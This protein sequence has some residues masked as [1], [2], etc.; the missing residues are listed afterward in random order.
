MCTT[1]FLF[2]KPQLLSKNDFTCIY[3]YIYLKRVP[4][5]PSIPL[6]KPLT[7]FSIMGSVTF[8]FVTY[9]WE[10]KTQHN[11]IYILYS[12]L[13][14]QQSKTK[15]H[16]NTQNIVGSICKVGFPSGPWKLLQWPTSLGMHCQHCAAKLLHPTSVLP[17]NSFS[18]ALSSLPTS[19]C[20]A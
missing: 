19:S 2:A 4:T 15:T 18:C 7:M 9:H 8:K 11:Y 20:S 6:K 10:R 1:G 17:A 12:F 5:L 13:R 3:I 14:G 16:K